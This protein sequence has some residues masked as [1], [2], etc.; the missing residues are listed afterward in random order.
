MTLESNGVAVR[1]MGTDRSLSATEP[2][3]VFYCAV[4]WHI[5][6]HGSV[7]PLGDI[8]RGNFNSFVGVN[9]G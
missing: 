6:R 3:F 5:G 7:N 4:R 9:S 8:R 1:V 2:E